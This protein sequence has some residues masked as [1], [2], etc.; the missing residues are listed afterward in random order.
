MDKRAFHRTTKTMSVTFCCCL[1]DYYSGNLT[2][3]SE[4]GMFISTPICFPLESRLNILI[5]SDKE[6]LNIPVRVRWIRKSQDKYDGIGV[7]VLEPTN[8]YLEF[9]S[10]INLT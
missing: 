2:N 5:P 10:C 6:M 9:V 1:T 3:I 4:R 7:E 8:K